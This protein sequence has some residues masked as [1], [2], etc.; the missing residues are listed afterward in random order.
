MNLRIPRRF[1]W[2]LG[3]GF[4]LLLAGPAFFFWQTGRA[5]PWDSANLRVHFQSMRY[6]RAGLVFTYRVAN[7]TRRPARLT[8]GDSRILIKQAAG[9]PPAG[10]PGIHWPLEIPAQSARDIE[11]RL[12]LPIPHQPRNA[13]HTARVLE[14]HLPEP[15]DIDSPLAPLP[16]TR[17]PVDNPPQTAPDADALVAASLASLDGFELRNDALRLLIVLPRAW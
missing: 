16:M 3:G 1:G 7:R 14:H 9:L 13:E 4:V 10:Y 11:V 5:E 6:E 15:R 17:P 8:A 12:E 2:I